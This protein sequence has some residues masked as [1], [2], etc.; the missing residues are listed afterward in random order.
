METTNL[1]KLF[2]QAESKLKEAESL[3]T[4][5]IEESVQ[6]IANGKTGLIDKVLDRNKSTIHVALKRGGILSRQK[7]ARLIHEHYDRLKRELAKGE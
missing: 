1:H 4:Q 7:T 2:E 5:Y 3:Y 6:D